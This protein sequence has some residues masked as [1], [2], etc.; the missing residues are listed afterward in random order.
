MACGLPLPD[1]PPGKTIFRGRDEV[2]E[3][4]DQFRSIWE[5]VVIELEEIELE[6][7]TGRGWTVIA[8]ARFR[9]LGQGSGAEVDRVFHYLLESDADLL[10]RRSRPAD[11]L[12]EARA[13]AGLGED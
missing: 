8:R 4:W 6:L 7:Q 3:L 9:G 10:L 5:S 1:L 2:R 11:S 13:L 12:A